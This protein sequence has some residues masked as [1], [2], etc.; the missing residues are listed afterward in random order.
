MI[1]HDLM[2]HEKG[3]ARWISFPSREYKDSAGNRQFANIIEFV[4]KDVATRFRENI[5]EALD[6]HLAE[7]RA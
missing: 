7:T 5:L 1:L 3:D 4:D 2:L 6:R